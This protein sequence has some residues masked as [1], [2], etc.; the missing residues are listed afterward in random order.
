LTGVRGVWRRLG[1]SGP[2]RVGVIPVLVLAVAL[3]FVFPWLPEPSPAGAALEHYA[4]EHDGGSI[5]VEKFDADGELIATES[6]NLATIPDLRS[7]TELG[8]DI[9][10]QL[11]DIYTSPEDMEDA[12]VVEVRRRTLEASGEI[13]DTTDTLVLEPRGLLLLASRSSETGTEVIFDQPAVLLPADL[14]PGKRWSSKG[15][16]GPVNYELDG[17]VVGSGAFESDLGSFDECLFVRTRLT[18]SGSGGQGD[19]VDYRDTYCAGVGLVESRELEVAGKTTQRS[20]VVSTDQ[21]PPESTAGL[22]PVPLTA[23]E[24]VAGDPASWRLGHFGRLKPSGEPS[25][26]SIPPTYVRTDPPVLLAAAEEGDLVALEVGKDPG[27]VRWRFHTEGNIYGPPAFDTASGR[28]YFGAT[29]KKLYALDA[30]GLFLWAFETGDNV[31]SRPVVAGDTVVFGSENRNVYGLDAGT[32]RERWKVST[33]GP[34]VSSPAFENGVVIIGSDDGAVYGLDPRTGDE[35][36][37]YIAKAAVEAPITAVG[38]VAYVASRSGEVTALDAKSGKV[39]W[40]TSQGKILRT[41]PAVGEEEVFVV[42][43]D[44]GLVAFDRR[45]G[46][47][48]WENPGGS[49]VG[50]PLVAGDELVVARSDGHIERLDFDGNRTGGWD[51]AVAGNPIDGDPTFSIGPVAGGGA[52]WAA[53]DKASV[54]RLGL[55]N[56]PSHIK[57][58][59]AD[60]FSDLPFYGDAPQYTATGYRGEAL[61]LGANNNVYLVD[62]ASGEA[63]RIAGLKGASGRPATEPLVAG[64]TLLA[65]SGDTLH[66]ARLPDVD[67]LW[68]FEGGSSL[69]PPVVAGQSVL[70][71]STKAGANTLNSLDLGSGDVRWKASLAGTGGVIAWGRTAYA[72]PAS[73]F[74]LDTGKLLWQAESGE[75]QASGGPALSASG[76]VLFAGTSGGGGEPASVAA[77]DASDGEEIWRAALGDELVS[78]ADRLRVSGDVVVAPV[79]SGDIVAL[80]AGSGEEV[81]RYT[82]PEPRLGNITVEGGEVWF[83]LQNGEVLALDAE[84]GEISARSNDYSLNLNS[85]SLSQRPVFVGGTLVLGVGTYVLGF[86]APEGLGG[87]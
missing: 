7:F 16:A 79:H 13:S 70:W 44:H 45:T 34:V 21:A 76:K 14:G 24:G 25:A 46:K 27:S 12:E 62:P 75:R 52:L 36:W 50:P 47:K 71:L 8:Q 48:L 49:Y 51:G 61:L 64:D 11:E 18:F 32:G 2:V 3:F 55:Q 53:T 58:I 80:D 4:P 20:T 39:T 87:P 67:E 73:A 37:R 6:Q 31:A 23:P 63:R 22:P 69:R 86:E 29:D 28:I 82:P 74:D 42:D 40:T 84:S 35:K 65:A 26:S 5:L 9:S 43:D 10:G 60:A 1:A 19:R 41:A 57:P 83:G 38:G 68:K 66:A 78:P 54:V 72:N 15:T 81:W 33:G 30:R 85:T 17:R 56:G 59:W 77:Y